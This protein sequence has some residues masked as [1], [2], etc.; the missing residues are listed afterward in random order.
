MCVQVSPGADERSCRLSTD[1]RQRQRDAV[2]HGNILLPAGSDR[3]DSR[4]EEGQT[5]AAPQPHQD[6]FS[7]P[8]PRGASSS[9]SAQEKRKKT[10]IQGQSAER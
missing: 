9:E 10:W 7:Q 1:S 2:A 5:P 6:G 3:E 8:L 4:Q